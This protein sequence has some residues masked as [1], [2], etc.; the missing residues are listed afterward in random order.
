MTTLAAELSASRLL[1]NIFGTSN[2][3]WANIIG[4]MLLYLAAGYF[5]GG[6]WA[7]RSPHP[8]TFYTILIVAAFLTALVP[9][10]ARPVLRFAAEAMMGLNAVVAGG[11]F[12]GVLIL[13][14]IPVTLLGCA[15]PFAIRLA[16][17][18]SRQAG[19]V[20]GRI[21]AISTLGSLIGTFLPVLVLIP[22][23]G[24]TGTFLFF[25][26]LL[27]VVAAFGLWGV[28]RRRVMLALVI[29]LIVAGAAS[30]SLSGSQRPLPGLIPESEIESEY[31][32][33]Q[34]VQRGEW[35]YLLLNEGQGIHSVYNPNQIETGMVWDYFLS[36]A[37]FNP[38][39]RVESFG[40][41]GLA[42]GT[43]ARQYTAVFGPIPIDGYEI[44]GAIVETGRRFMGLTEPNI[45]A[46][47]GDG[48]VELARSPRRYSVIGVDAYRVPYI[49]WQLTTREF[50]AE[51]RGKLVEEGALVVNV[52]RTPNDHRL[53]E[54]MVGTIGSIFPSVYV[55]DIPDTFNSI[56]YAT[57]QPTRVENLRTNLEQLP[58]GVHPLL[59]NAL[60]RTLTHLVPTPQ[61]DTVFTDDLA[62]VEWI[63]NAIVIDFFLQG[64]LELFGK[65]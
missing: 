54:A 35:R 37:F 42:A 60:A 3:V 18:D 29:P 64:G 28:D 12:L 14:S 7:D 33:I 52:G 59:R 58:E 11:S 63:S 10:I 65:Q 22:T 20:T 41:I 1:G 61:S 44:D 6:R 4:L 47:I 38:A 46:I 31:N 55:V 9:L 53:V 40:N 2:L 50:F 26:G 13:F 48:R 62:P 23:L 45:N 27:F 30:V 34:V 15:S 8:R 24:T 36:A 39:P 16:V 19:T 43:A 21:Y 49:P 57:V 32:F 17:T 56:V 25:S 51:V 5:I